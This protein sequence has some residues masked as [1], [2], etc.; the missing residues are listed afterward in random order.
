MSVDNSMKISWAKVWLCNSRNTLSA[1][2]ANALEAENDVLLDDD[3]QR[4]RE[5]A[6][7]EGYSSF[8][9]LLQS[10][11]SSDEI[12]AEIERYES[13]TMV[14]VDDIE[15]ED[16]LRDW[17]SAFDILYAVGICDT[18]DALRDLYGYGHF[19]ELRKDIAEALEYMEV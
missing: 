1:E 17:C 15:D 14:G 4:L 12:V 11:L 16:T 6:R 7:L 9:T 18:F 10:G 8:D 3:M 13:T 19:V 5:F 2:V